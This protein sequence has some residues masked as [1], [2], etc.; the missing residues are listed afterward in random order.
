[1]PPWLTATFFPTRSLTDEMPEPFLTRMPSPAA[2]GS[3]AVKNLKPGRWASEVMPEVMEPVAMSSWSEV[4]G[5]VVHRNGEPQPAQGLD[6]PDSGAGSDEYGLAF[7]DPGETD[8]PRP[9]P[10]R[11]GPQGRY[12]A[13]FAE[14][15]RQGVGEVG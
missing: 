1:M 14:Q 13:A 12:V 10:A 7:L 4:D 6:A 15:A 9:L 5:D 11:T 3:T 8:Q 2:S